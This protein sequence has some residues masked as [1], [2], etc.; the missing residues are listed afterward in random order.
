[1]ERYEEDVRNGKEE[2]NE[3]E[4]R[5]GKKEGEKTG[6]GMGSQRKGEILRTLA[7]GDHTLTQ[8]R[9]RVLSPINR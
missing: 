4:R 7:L 3:S 5:G 2:G 8:T 6:S 9:G 1:M